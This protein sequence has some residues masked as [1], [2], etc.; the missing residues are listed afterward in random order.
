MTS[1]YNIHQ[2]LQNFQRVSKQSD[3]K[4]AGVNGHVPQLCH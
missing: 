1:E 2:G 4:R 3:R